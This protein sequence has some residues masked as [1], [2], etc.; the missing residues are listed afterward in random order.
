M[1][2]FMLELASQRSVAEP[3]VEQVL[4]ILFELFNENSL[5]VRQVCAAASPVR[6]LYVKVNILVI[7]EKVMGRLAE[8]L[9]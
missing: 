8:F 6:E 1:L 3:L 2:L 9:A 7:F 4:Q 5:T